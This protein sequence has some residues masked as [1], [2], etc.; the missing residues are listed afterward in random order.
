MI[1]KPLL[2]LIIITTLYGCNDR[3]R[4]DLAKG[5][6][7]C[8]HNG[9]LYKLYYVIHSSKEVVCKDGTTLLFNSKEWKEIAGEKVKESLMGEG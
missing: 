2:F 8:E 5:E 3:N 6:Q 1:S 9:E 7:V 4:M